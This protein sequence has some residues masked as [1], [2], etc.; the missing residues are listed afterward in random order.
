MAAAPV[1]Q[2][3]WSLNL[4]PVAEGIP[5][6][7][8]RPSHVD[9]V[10]LHAHHSIMREAHLGLGAVLVYAHLDDAEESTACLLPLP[11]PFLDQ[12]T[13]FVGEVGVVAGSV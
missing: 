11:L 12:S 5:R 3:T 6:L 8:Y 4:P 13:L 10:G 2:G 9:L 1:E 7:R